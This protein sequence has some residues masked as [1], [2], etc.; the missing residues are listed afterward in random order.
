MQILLNG[1]PAELP[2]PMTVQALL[3]RLKIDPRL[4]AVECDRIVIKRARYA[5]TMITAG[6][7]V[8]IVAF[9]GGGSSRSVAIG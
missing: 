8:E 9:V 3:D 6:T 4:V 5:E 7:E 1:D 2:G